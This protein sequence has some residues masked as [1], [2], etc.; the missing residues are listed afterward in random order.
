MASGPSSGKQTY[1]EKPP[2]NRGTGS[3]A[4]RAGHAAN[5]TPYA[6]AELDDNFLITSSAGVTFDGGSV[7]VST[8]QSYPGST[9]QTGSGPDHDMAAPLYDGA[10]GGAVSSTIYGGPDTTY[11]PTNPAPVTNAT[12]APISELSLKGGYGAQAAVSV[13]ALSPF[14]TSSTPSLNG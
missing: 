7:S 5:A 10:S 11:S 1:E 2:R 4:I 9:D 6:F 13:G 8:S 3:P 12:P 14:T